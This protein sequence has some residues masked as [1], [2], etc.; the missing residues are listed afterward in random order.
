[1]CLLCHLWP[2]TV[3]IIWSLIMSQPIKSILKAMTNDVTASVKRFWNFWNS[4]SAA[5]L[6]LFTFFRCSLIGN[7]D[8]RNLPRNSSTFASMNSKGFITR[9][10]D[11]QHVINC[12]LYTMNVQT[13]PKQVTCGSGLELKRSNLER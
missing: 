6:L 2:T 3:L 1:M 12:Y 13:S 9:G 8:I 10:G 4:A 7:V 5:A 11:F